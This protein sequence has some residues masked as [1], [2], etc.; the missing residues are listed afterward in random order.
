[1]LIFPGLIEMTFDHGDG[2]RR[3]FV[4]LLAHE[5]PKIGQESTSE[6][7]LERQEG[8][9]EQGRMRKRDELGRGCRRDGGK[10]GMYAL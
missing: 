2:V 10:A 1:V 9:V 3:V 5:T 6:G 7:V 4:E 8:G